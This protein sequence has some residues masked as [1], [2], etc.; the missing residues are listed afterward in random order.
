M[1]RGLARRIQALNKELRELDRMLT[2][3]IAETA[4]S[5]FDLHGVGTD[6]AASLM[7]AAGDIPDRI[8][9][10]PDRGL[11]LCGTTP[12]PSVSRKTLGHR[13]NP[14]GD[15]QANAALHRIVVTRMSSPRNQD[16]RGKLE[17]R[18]PINSEI[19]R[20]LKRSCGRPNLQTS[21]CLSLESGSDPINRLMWSQTYCPQNDQSTPPTSLGGPCCPNTEPATNRRGPSQSC[22]QTAGTL[23]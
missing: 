5:L 12:L 11:D 2:D 14:V 9:S 10:E 8:S 6:T 19:M 18:R 16:I 22:P 20:C 3:L 4:P 7:V 17:N 15:R 23:T 21:S 13:L 1:I